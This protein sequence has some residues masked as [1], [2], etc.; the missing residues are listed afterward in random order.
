MRDYRDK[1]KEEL[2]EII[3]KLEE[4][5]TNCSL[6]EES[7]PDNKQ[8]HFREKYGEEILDAIPD[9]L[10]VFD[11]NLNYIE[12]LSS[13]QTNHVEGLSNVDSSQPNLKDFMP[14]KAYRSVRANMEK[15]IRTRQPSMGE[16][17][18]IYKGEVHHYENLVCPLGDKYLLC[19]C[20]DVTS[21]VN[22]QRELAAARIKAE[23]ADRLKSAFLANMSHEIRT[24]LNAIVGFSRL[25]ID[26]GY[27]GDKE[28]YCNIIERNSNLLLNLFN[29]ILDLSSMEAGSLEF[30][31]E[32]VNLYFV[33]LEETARFCEKVNEGVKLILDDVDK[34]LCMMG[35]RKRIMQ[36]L[37]NLLS[38]AVKFTPKGEIHLGYKLVGT[39]VQFYVKDT[40]IG[41]PASRV[42]KIFERF[43][44][45][46]NFAQGTGLGLTISR[47]LVERMGGRI[48]VRS[49]EGL[50]TTFYF[51]LPFVN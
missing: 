44:K 3:R 31:K 7:C 25:V 28:D 51:T 30:Y 16:H 8:E 6:P 49:S 41:I 9:M 48:W 15:V 12:L 36:A 32:K 4:K 39:V 27:G 35:D 10:T 21:R 1:T 42:A 19:M 2:L 46:N 11:F 40:G 34:E 17:S 45:I 43:G 38:N 13:P 26:S 14:E 20:R 5:V 23:E 29:D 18:L 37:T 22:A 33:C 47:M 24:P 50:G